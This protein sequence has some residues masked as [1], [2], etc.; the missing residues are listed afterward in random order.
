MLV[1]NLFQW[2]SLNQ[3]VPNANVKAGDRVVIVDHL[4]PNP[5][6][7]EPGYLLEV[8]REGSTVDV[9]AVPISWVTALS[10][11]WGQPET[12]AVNKKI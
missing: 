8:F 5:Q 9:V 4:S 2:V 11:S 7:L 12:G 1:A 10:E 3:A 6:Q